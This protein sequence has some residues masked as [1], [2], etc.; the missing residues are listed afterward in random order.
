M[1]TVIKYS[2]DTSKDP[3]LLNVEWEGEILKCTTCTVKILDGLLTI[4]S[5]SKSKV[6]KPQSKTDVS[7]STWIFRKVAYT[8]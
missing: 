4:Q 7:E 1:E 5:V 8:K 3:T 2:L 6:D